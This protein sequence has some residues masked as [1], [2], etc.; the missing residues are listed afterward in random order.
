MNFFTFFLLLLGAAIT[1]SGQIL[2]K[3]GSQALQKTLTL[4]ENYWPNLELLKKIF[5]IIF[6]PHI[7]TAFVL[8][9]LGSFL[10]LKILTRGDLGYLYPILIGLT[11]IITTTASALLFKETIG[12]LK[13]MGIA[14][15][16]TGIFLINGFK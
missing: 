8:Y 13:I 11:I 10:W 2:M 1:G 3:I 7:F 15:I 12:V 6:E 16:I 5:T 14:L 9:F 4:P